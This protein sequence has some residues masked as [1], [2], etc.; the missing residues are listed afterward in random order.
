MGTYYKLFSKNAEGELF[1]LMRRGFEAYDADCIV[2][3]ADDCGPFAA[4]KTKEDALAMLADEHRL[5]K[6][7]I[8][9][10]AEFYKGYEVVLYKVKGVRSK[11]GVQY[12]PYN[13]VWMGYPYLSKSPECN[14]IVKSGVWSV[15]DGAVLLDEFE[16]LSQVQADEETELQYAA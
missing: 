16:I 9:E 13:V 11:D 5:Q 8:G 3:R 2:Q 7:S 15:Y 1:P 10:M 14:D 12:G 6:A 4:L